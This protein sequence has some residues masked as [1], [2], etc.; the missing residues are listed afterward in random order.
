MSAVD[1]V[2]VT[3]TVTVLGPE[4]S[5]MVLT[6]VTDAT[7]V[8]D[9]VV[10]VSVTTVSSVR[11]GRVQVK[12]SAVDSVSVGRT[13]TVTVSGPEVSPRVLTSVMV[14]TTGVPDEVAVVSVTTVSSVNVG[15]SQV[16]ILGVESGPVKMTVSVGIS[17]VSPTV[18]TSVTDTTGAELVVTEVSKLKVG[19]VQ[20]SIPVSDEEG[21]LLTAVSS[22]KVGSVQ[23]SIP[24][25][26]EAVSS[27]NVGSVT[28]KSFCPWLLSVTTA[29]TL[30]VTVTT[31]GG[32]LC[33][34]LLGVVTTVTL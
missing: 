11:V 3:T 29:V 25:S 13:V 22:D 31:S 21:L 7:G 14:T 5:T 30:S 28:V 33:N 19:N 16:S 15:R 10:G 32:R 18:V 2:S 9:E 26:D 1:P 6:L 20:V 4:V 12:M 34:W 23:V 8:P 17:E 24:V 27:D